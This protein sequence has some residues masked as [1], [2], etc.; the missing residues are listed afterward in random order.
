MASLVFQIILA[1]LVAGG[2]ILALV[3]EAAKKSKVAITGIVLLLLG[4]AVQV[5][6]L[7]ADYETQVAL[8]KTVTSTSET[9]TAVRDSV[10]VLLE[11]ERSR[12]DTVITR[13]DSQMNKQDTQ[14]LDQRRQLTKQDQQ[15]ARQTE[16]LNKQDQTLRNLEMVAGLA[17]RNLDQNTGGRGFTY[18]QWINRFPDR[19]AFVS[20]DV[21]S[22]IT[23]Y[24]LTRSPNPIEITHVSF[25]ER[26]R[27]FPKKPDT[28]F[29]RGIPRKLRASYS[30]TLGRN[31]IWFDELN[32]EPL[33]QL[34]V[35][36]SDTALFFT[37]T[38]KQQNA[39]INQ[40]II[41]RKIEVPQGGRGKFWSRA[42][43]I[44]SEKLKLDTSIVDRGF[45]RENGEVN[46]ATGW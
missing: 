40:I 24:L 10:K 38:I 41:F 15:L 18:I 21:A 45:P 19:R 39:T 31:A 26:Y 11:S 8:E 44:F 46:W 33:V 34:P 13:F 7:T 37:A 23:F 32:S 35:M 1:V 4:L 30:D 36:K 2:G 9:A 25:R 6:L 43:K 17:Q 29:N 5:W 27:N 12:Y 16:Q 3:K 22:N 28:L 14:L 42:T 20:P